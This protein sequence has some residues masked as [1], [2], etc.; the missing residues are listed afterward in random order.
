MK[1]HNIGRALNQPYE[2][3]NTKQCMIWAT[4]NKGEIA[5]ETIDGKTNEIGPWTME[6]QS[7]K[8]NGGKLMKYCYK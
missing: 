2:K 8:G 7:E 3:T 4:D 5:A 6:N 1:S